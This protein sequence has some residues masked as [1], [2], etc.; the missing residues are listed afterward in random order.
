MP[1]HPD[2]FP[3]IRSALES[4]GWQGSA[5]AQG[6]EFALNERVA[7]GTVRISLRFDPAQPWII[8][9][10]TLTVIDGS[11]TDF[12]WHRIGDI[13]CYLDPQSVEWDP[14]SSAFV[15]HVVWAADR[16]VSELHRLQK[17]ERVAQEDSEFIVHWGGA[18]SYLDIRDA[19]WPPQTGARI[20]RLEL[21]RP[22][23]PSAAPLVVYRLS[24][25]GGLGRYAAFGEVRSVQLVPAVYVDL[26]RYPFRQ[27]QGWPPRN[28][29]QL[30]AWFQAHRPIGGKSMWRQIASAMF[31][32]GS[33]VSNVFVI[34]NTKAGRYGALLDV[35]QDGINGFRPGTA[36]AE[37]LHG[38]NSL[39][40]RVSVLRSTFERL[41]DDFVLKRNAPDQKAALAGKRIHLIGAGAV[42][43]SLADLLVQTGAGAGGGALHIFDFDVLRPENLGR[44]LLG[45]PYL[46][47]NKAEGIAFFLRRNRLSSCVH[48]HPIP[49]TDPRLHREADLV[50]DAT[51]AP[52]VGAALSNAARAERKWSLLSAF[53]EGEGW[54]A[55]TYLYQ[56]RAGE[57]C[58]TCLEP[59]IGGRSSHVRHD[60][61]PKSR[62]DGCGSTY[63]PYRAAAATTAA[64]LASE[65]ACDWAAGKPVSRY[66]AFRLPNAPSHVKDSCLS[67]PA[68]RPSC[69]CSQ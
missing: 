51:A 2:L 42:G 62:D 31:A 37:T 60:H 20:E 27:P 38:N 47:T 66:R 34:I 50:I 15:S 67:S 13:F 12:T 65:L 6:I 32:D 16:A 63:T 55:G 57:A 40:Q 19:H 64:A 1:S 59:W 53:V 49:G 25:D 14:E 21:G 52:Y 22:E 41:D 5:T 26:D 8:P 3:A 11:P 4:R 30:N 58:R 10:A 56:G 46:G 24:G 45:V 43:S 36:L 7:G 48:G 9:I 69:I 18:P 44:H 17:G 68:S 35:G 23:A 28:L 39:T 61:A 54:V 33:K 29:A